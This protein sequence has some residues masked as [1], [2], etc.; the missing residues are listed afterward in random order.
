M[1]SDT[2]RAAIVEPFRN[3]IWQI[4]KLTDLREAVQVVNR[5][6]KGRFR[7]CIPVEDINAQK[8]SKRINSCLAIQN[9]VLS[10]LISF[11]SFLNIEKTATC[12]LKPA[13]ITDGR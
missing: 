10:Y 11:S 1:S 3:G 5:Y 4:D 9:I 7:T 12:Y 6:Q 8:C 13:I 2:F